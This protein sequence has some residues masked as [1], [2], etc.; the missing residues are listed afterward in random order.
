MLRYVPSVAPTTA[1]ASISRSIS[2]LTSPDTA[3]IVDAG[4][5]S[6]KNSPWTFPTTS[7]SP[8]PLKPGTDWQ[9]LTA[10]VDAFNGEVTHPDFRGISLIRTGDSEAVVLGLCTARES[11]DEVSRNRAGPWFAEHIRPYLAGA[12]NRS[13]G[14]VIAGALTS[15]K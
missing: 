15:Q 12:V 3:S 1:S 2:G 5:M 7:Q 14:E 4:R 6:R 11:L 13:V 8:M 10:K 9:A